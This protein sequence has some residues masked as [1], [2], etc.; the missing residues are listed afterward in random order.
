[1]VAAIFI[2][3]CFSSGVFFQLEKRRRDQ[4]AVVEKQRKLL[5]A[6]WDCLETP[7]DERKKFLGKHSGLNPKTI[8][9]VS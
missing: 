3:C 8:L 2:T 5:V 9:D 6:I 7:E 4:E 1:M